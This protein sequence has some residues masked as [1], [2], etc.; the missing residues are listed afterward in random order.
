MARCS[1]LAFVYASFLAL[2]PLLIGGIS[3]LS[4]FL[5]VGG[6]TEITGVSQIVEFLIALIGLGVAID[7]SLLVVSR[8]REE[9]AAGRDNAGAVVQAMNHAGRAVVFSGLT[10]AIGLLSMIVL[11]VPM[12][13]SVGYGGVLVP[14]VSVVVAVTLLPV[15]LATV[16]PRL[17]WPRLRTERSASRVFSAWA[18]GVY[19]HRW[20][21]AAAG[22]AVIGALMLP[23]MSL[24]LGGPGSGAEATAGPAHNALST[25]TRG[26]IP[27]G[28]ITPA[29]VL[30]SRAP[31][32]AQLDRLS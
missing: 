29:E 17:D 14:L 23:A 6:L 31:A 9:R 30:V 8:W 21:A 32:P 16:G 7:Y 5:L 25:L 26:G 28:V 20:V 24:H 11:P 27:S 18:R 4:T 2:L 1:I 13:R 12:L 19:Q 10:V 15:I 3:V 22:L